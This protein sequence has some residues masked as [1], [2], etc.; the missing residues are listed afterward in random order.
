MVACGVELDGGGHDAWCGAWGGRV[1]RV[2]GRGHLDW[3]ADG[4]HRGGFAVVSGSC[5]TGVVVRYWE[6]LAQEAARRG[7]PTVVYLDRALFHR[8]QDFRRCCERWLACGLR[9]RY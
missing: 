4:A 9:V 5:R 8:L 1:G 6:G 3:Q 7:V 2:N